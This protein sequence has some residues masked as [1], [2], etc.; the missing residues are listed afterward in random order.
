MRREHPQRRIGRLAAIL[1]T[2]LLLFAGVRSN[3]MQAQM[4][5]VPTAAPHD[6]AA[7]AHCMRM[8]DRT[9]RAPKSGKAAAARCG[10]CDVA[11]Q[12]P[13]CTAPPVV[14]PAGAV[15]WVAWRTLPSLGPRGPPAVEARA[16]D[17]PALS[18]IA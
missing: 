5:S 4:A 13:V 18:L 12:P 8:G 11:G 16:R 17:P 7:M 3:V 14:G 9:G 1:A 6:V 15:A 10:F 2:A